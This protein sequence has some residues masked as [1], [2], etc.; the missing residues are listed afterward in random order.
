MIIAESISTQLAT[1]RLEHVHALNRASR[2]KCAT[3]AF[4]SETF[5]TSSTRT[6]FI[7][8]HTVHMYVRFSHSLTSRSGNSHII[9]KYKTIFIVNVY[10]H[11]YYSHIM[12]EA[13]LL[14][15][16][17][18]GY[19]RS[20]FRPIFWISNMPTYIIM[21]FSPFIIIIIIIFITR[22]RYYILTG[23]YGL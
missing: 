2:R 20:L 14:Q 9:N 5:F 3:G 16:L 19:I 15:M 6:N 7:S 1:G 18:N 4:T 23:P 22:N 13:F 8:R 10:Y 21:T 12:M 11:H 17:S